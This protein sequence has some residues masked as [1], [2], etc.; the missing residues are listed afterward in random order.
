M[1]GRGRMA[2]TETVA[3]ADESVR[4]R[5]L[6]AASRLFAQKG[7]SAT[8]VREIVEAVGV[9]KPVLYYYFENKEGLY[10]ELMRHALGHAEEVIESTL[11][12]AGSARERIEQLCD[13]TFALIL[14]NLDFVRVMDSIYYGPPQGAP[15]F[16]FDEFHRSFENAVCTLVEEGM[17]SGE[18]RSADPE[19]VTW[20]ILGALDIAK[21]FHLCHPERS[22]GRAGLACLL[23]VVFEGALSRVPAAKEHSDE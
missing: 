9:T 18:L 15:P 20:A 1:P 5:L 2:E 13:R 17:E 14:D 3:I 11:E 10:L 8:T 6:D 23:D 22:K 19:A 4:H 16:D 21:G 12:S 7:Y